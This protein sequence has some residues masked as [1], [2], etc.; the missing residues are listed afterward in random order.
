MKV[1]SLYICA[2]HV[3]MYV[4][5]LC[6]NPR[7][8]YESPDVHSVSKL[9]THILTYASMHATFHMYMYVRT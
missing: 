2:T 7:D 8:K 9:T 3:C 4:C 6:T 5:V 1:Q